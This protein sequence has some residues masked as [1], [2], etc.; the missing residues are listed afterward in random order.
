MDN[1]TVNSPFAKSRKL[2]LINFPKVGRQAREN[3][4]FSLGMCASLEIR[5]LPKIAS[6]SGPDSHDNSA[7][8]IGRGAVWYANGKSREAREVANK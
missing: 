3:V 6:C 7:K 4:L 5:T 8:V 2:A 1:F